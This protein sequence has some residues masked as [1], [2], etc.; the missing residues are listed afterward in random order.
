MNEL[1][2]LLNEEHKYYR[3]KWLS[4]IIEFLENNLAMENSHGIYVLGI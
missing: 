4:H 1:T 3:Q 2:Y